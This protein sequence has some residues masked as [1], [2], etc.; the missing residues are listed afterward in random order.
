M[1]GVKGKLEI[2]GGFEARFEPFADL[3][4]GGNAHA[5]SLV[6]GGLFLA[7]VLAA[8]TGQN[9]IPLQPVGRCR[10]SDESC[11]RLKVLV[12]APLMRR[13]IWGRLAVS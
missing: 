1:E 7:G 13:M 6:D 3:R 8:P 10:F 12:K 5:G 2:R 9:K 11:S 4:D